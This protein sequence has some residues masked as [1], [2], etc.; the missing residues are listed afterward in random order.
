MNQ[1]RILIVEDEATV[2][3]DIAQQLTRWAMNRWLRRRGERKPSSWPNNYVP[4][5]Y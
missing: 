3:R 4:T 1:T 2:A 5:W